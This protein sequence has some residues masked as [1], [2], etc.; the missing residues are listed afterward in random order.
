MANLP[1]RQTFIMLSV[2]LAVAGCNDDRIHNICS[3]HPELCQD[4]VDDGW[5]RYERTDIIR[6][7]FYLKEE[8]TDRRKYE[9]MRNL[10]R[11]LKCA[12]RSTNIEYKNAREQKSPRVEG[13]LAAGDQLAQLDAATRN[14]KD[15]YL[16]LWHWTNNTNE[17]ARQ[18]F[19]ALEGQPALEEPELQ[20]A[21]GGIYAKREPQKA[22]ALMQHALSLYREGDQVNGRILTSLSTLYMGQKEYGQAYL[23]GKVSESFQNAAEVSASRFSLYHSL[24][25]QQQEGLDSQAAIL[26][27]QLKSGTYRP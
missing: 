20:L 27:E 16:L 24:S 22:I 12:E 19:L 13:M 7:R 2:G 17:L 8:G 10:E 4:L 18:Q 11:Y 23:W 1:L 9:L 6:S 5:C 26:V 3:N 21:L 15:P 25:K 14:A